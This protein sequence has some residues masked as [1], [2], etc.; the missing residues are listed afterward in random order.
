MPHRPPTGPNPPP[1]D[2][3]CD[4]GESFGAYVLGSDEEVMPHITSASVAC[5]YHGG[6]P[7]VMR[8]TVRLARQHG[9]AVGAHP[10]LQDRAG[11]GRR[12][13]QVTAQE[14][15]D[16]VLYQVGALEAI[17]RSEGIRLA[18]VKPHGALYNMAARERPLAEAIARAVRA[19]DPSLILFVLPHSEMQRAGEAA[20]L[21]VVP[22]GFAD[23]SYEPDGSL[24]P[25]ARRGS[26]IHDIQE[27]VR[28]VVRMARDGTVTATDGSDI[29]LSAATLCVH[30]DTPGAASLVR[31]LRSALERS[32][33]IVA[34]PGRPAR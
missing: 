6:D 20:G 34:P 33:V 21:T 29:P 14:V 28:R 2:L 19:F 1:L 24:T 4:M 23:R 32:G 12:E 13:M 3:N 27:I 31:E 26:V 16:L 18:H 5:G 7:A 30:G 15:E 25:R 10:G 11:F 8:R 17:A 22:E 9:V